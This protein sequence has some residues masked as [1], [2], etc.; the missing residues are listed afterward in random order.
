MASS[1]QVFVL[2]PLAHRISYEANARTDSRPG[3]GL[4]RYTRDLRCQSRNCWSGSFLIG[5]RFL[6]G[7]TTR[8]RRAILQYRAQSL[9]WAKYETD[10][11]ECNREGFLV[12]QLK[13]NAKGYFQKNN[14]E[15]LN[16][17]NNLIAKAEQRWLLHGAFLWLQ[18]PAPKTAC[19]Q[20]TAGNYSVRSVR[21]KPG[22]NR[23]AR[24]H[25]PA[26]PTNHAID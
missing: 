11:Q 8:Q 12:D 3:Q 24:G 18:P 21:A 15:C 7:R 6:L 14:A 2:G 4:K 25:S 1:N 19:D 5:Q 17:L 26:R 22:I 23:L 10:G 16:S 13:Y 9:P 20:W